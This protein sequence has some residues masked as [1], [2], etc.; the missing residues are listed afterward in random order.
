MF[1]RILLCQAIVF[2]CTTN[3]SYS[4]YSEDIGAIEV[5][6]I[7]IVTIIIEVYTLQY[8]KMDILYRSVVFVPKQQ[9]NQW[10]IIIIVTWLSL[11][12]FFRQLSWPRIILSTKIFAH[13]IC[14]WLSLLTTFMTLIAF[15]GIS[16]FPFLRLFLSF[17]CRSRVMEVCTERKGGREGEME[18]NPK[19]HAFL[20]K[21]LAEQQPVG[22]W[23]RT[24]KYE[25]PRTMKTIGNC[26]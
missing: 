2:S 1:E 13:N 6:Y 10:L 23:A 24:R 26:A 4:D 16:I 19:C 12:A 11:T 20:V 15:I 25:T 9:S 7:I 3:C 5:L 14:R 17:H 22:R 21:V 18:R 8:C